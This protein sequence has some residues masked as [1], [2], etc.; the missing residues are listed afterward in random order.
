[1][2]TKLLSLITVTLIVVLPQQV[3]ASPIELTARPAMGDTINW[4]QL[5]TPNLTLASPQSFTSTGGITGNLSMTGSLS[6]TQQCCIGITGTFSGDF[7]PG[8][9]VLSTQMGLPLTI[10]FN[11]PVETVGAQ[12]QDGRIGDLFTAEILAF[13]GSVLLATFTETGFSGDV[14]DNSDIYLGVQDATADITSVTYLTFT[15]SPEFEL[16]SAN[17]N[18]MTIAATPLPSSLSLLSIGLGVM[19]LFG[20]RR[21]RTIACV[22]PRQ[23][24]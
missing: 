24:R 9:I 20:L 14:G 22:E 1:M 21:K 4:S 11:T 13:S 10:N 17:I 2:T 7:A 23:E 6:L 8:D 12:I 5:G 16:Q 19:S 18:E 15:S 3:Y